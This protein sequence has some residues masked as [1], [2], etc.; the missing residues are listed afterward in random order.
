MKFAS[1][2]LLALVA[3]L[4][5]AGPIQHLVSAIEH[6][7]FQRTHFLPNHQPCHREVNASGHVLVHR[8]PE[9]ALVRKEVRSF[10]SKCQRQL[11]PR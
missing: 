6:F 10:L 3:C 7:M 8:N 2:S 11:D 1:F 4:V 5:H 9:S